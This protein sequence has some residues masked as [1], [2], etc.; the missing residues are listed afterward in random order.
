MKPVK[1][2]IF[3]CDGV[4]FN[5][6]EANRAYYNEIAK[7]AGRAPLTEEEMAYCHMHT[8]KES[9]EYIFRKDPEG[10]ERAFNAA[11]EIDYVRFLPLMAKEP[12]MEDTVRLIRPAVKTA[13]STNRSTTMPRLI[14][15]YRL[16]QLFDQIVCALDVKYPKP[17]PEGVFLILERL[18]LSPEE[19][20][21]IG[22]SKVDEVTAKNAGTRLIAY[23]NRQLDADFH[24]DNFDEIG[25][26]VLGLAGK[27]PVSARP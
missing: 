21:Y 27:G 1:I 12:G 17:D 20:I 13:I 16:D 23:K 25:K 19:A 10:M 5:S 24:A 15:I 2:A 4:L 7:M 6:Y 9:I 11:R 3:D 22:D 26:I 14:D 8:A 18:G